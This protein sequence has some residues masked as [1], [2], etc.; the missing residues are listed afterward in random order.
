MY[1]LL[2]KELDAFTYLK[3]SLEI[4]EN[5][6]TRELLNIST[7]LFSKKITKNS[8]INY[9]KG[10]KTINTNPS[11]S[12]IYFNLALEE[13]P[14][15]CLCRIKLA[16]IYSKKEE[17][18]K[19]KEELLQCVSNSDFGNIAKIERA[20]IFEKEFDYARASKE[21]KKIL[22]A[23]TYLDSLLKQNEI[24]NKFI[25]YKQALKNK[26][27]KKIFDL[28]S[29]FFQ[30]RQNK[31]TFIE[32]MLEIYTNKEILDLRPIDLNLLL[33]DHGYLSAKLT[34]INNSTQEIKRENI[35]YLFVKSQD[36]AFVSSEDK[37]ILETYLD[38]NKE[39]K[40]KY[41]LLK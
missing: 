35:I 18:D 40:T 5:E 23:T 17:R 19:A 25:I 41:E 21:I 11:A 28:Q 7:L 4:K 10:A 20:K 39:L 8:F 6:T 3:K 30:E 15:F 36:W 33:A 1:I 2:D 37:N 16:Q 38:Q 32:K 26:N 13:S 9:L 34:I 22:E 29:N 27:F 14:N 31:E 12:I 24:Y